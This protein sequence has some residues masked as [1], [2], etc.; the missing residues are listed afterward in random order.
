MVTIIG[1]FWY[2]CRIKKGS[3]VQRKLSVKLTE[4]LTPPM[5]LRAHPLT[6]GEALLRCST[7]DYISHRMVYRS[8]LFNLLDKYSAL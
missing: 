2:V 1:R 3:L 5:P 6:Q 4:G 8:T 7:A